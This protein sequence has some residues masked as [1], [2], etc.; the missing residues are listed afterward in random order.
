M[1][2]VNYPYHI[3]LNELKVKL[4]NEVDTQSKMAINILTQNG[5]KGTPERVIL[6]RNK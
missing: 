2:N 3:A 4:P 1:I 5:Y 6:K